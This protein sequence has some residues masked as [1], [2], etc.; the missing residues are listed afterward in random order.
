[1]SRH[2]QQIQHPGS[3]SSPSRTLPS[4]SYRVFL[5]HLPAPPAH[6]SPNRSPARVHP[7]QSSR[8]TFWSGWTDPFGR[9]VPPRLFR[10]DAFISPSRLCDLRLSSKASSV[11]NSVCRATPILILFFRIGKLRNMLRICLSCLS[12]DTGSRLAVHAGRITLFM[13]GRRVSD[14]G[15]VCVRNY[16]SY[17]RIS[18][19]LDWQGR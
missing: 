19:A 13:L 15:A 3:S 4:G 12:D 8:A 5:P 14:D 10:S 6:P 9:S 17:F 7:C 11:S 18:S 2:P 1:M 16:E